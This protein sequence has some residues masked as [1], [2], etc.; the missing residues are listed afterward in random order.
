LF[1]ARGFLLFDKH[2]F[3]GLY[4]ASGYGRTPKKQ[5]T[6]NRS[7]KS[8]HV[9]GWPIMFSVDLNLLMG[10]DNVSVFHTGWF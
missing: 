6:Q 8:P 9:E 10:M 5:Y 2:F 4:V 3:V 1:L 7:G